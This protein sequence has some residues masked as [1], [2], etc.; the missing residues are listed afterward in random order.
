MSYSAEHVTLPSHWVVGTRET[1]ENWG[2]K[3]LEETTVLRTQEVSQSEEGTG[4]ELG[5]MGLGFFTVLTFKTD[6]FSNYAK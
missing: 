5:R 6:V 3:R 4:P 2:H 1:I